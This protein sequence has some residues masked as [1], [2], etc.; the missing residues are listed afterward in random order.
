MRIV[1]MGT[2][3]FATG[4]LKALADAGYEIAAV[5]TQPDKPKGRGKAMQPTPVKEMARLSA[6]SYR[7]RCWRY[8]PWDVSMS[9]RR[10]FLLTGEPPPYSGRSSTGKRSPA[11]PSCVWMKGW[12]PGI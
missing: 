4:T 12:T 5:V 1:F 7:R 6:R 11:L 8:R 10:C 3:D 9:M 2:P